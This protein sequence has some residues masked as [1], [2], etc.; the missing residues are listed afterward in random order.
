MHSVGRVVAGLREEFPELTVSKVRFLEAEGIVRPSRTPSGYRQFS[1]A[2]VERLTFA[3][4]AQRDRFWPLRVVRE[5]LDA[6]DRGLTVD[7][8]TGVPR[9]AP[10]RPPTLAQAS[11][12]RLT[13]AEL[14]RSTGLDPGLADDLLQFGLLRPSTSGH[15]S[16]HDL[17]V[18]AAAAELAPYGLTGRHLRGFRTAADREVGLIEQVMTGRRQ[19]EDPASTARI[20]ADW[21][22][23][24]HSALVHAALDADRGTVDP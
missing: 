3:L 15:F 1:D 7:E 17:K 6:L 4:R 2:D 12:V 19:E 20:L 14:L 11:A 23:A 18:A 21:C 22:A 24:L 13:R 9:A 10:L 5:A 8:V 16:G